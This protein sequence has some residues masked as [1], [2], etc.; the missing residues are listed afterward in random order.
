MCRDPVDNKISNSPPPSSPSDRKH[1]ANDRDVIT[2]SLP[3]SQQPL[4]LSIIFHAINYYLRLRPWDRTD[5]AAG[6]TCEPDRPPARFPTP[7]SPSGRTARKPVCVRIT[8][9]RRSAT[10]T[11]VYG[12]RTPYVPRICRS[13]AACAP[14]QRSHTRTGPLW[15]SHTR[16]HAAGVTNETPTNV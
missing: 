8:W 1:D 7:A 12:F 14:S 2:T 11:V 3:S 6:N 4:F 15:V 10:A 5:A 13:F 9:V 16:T